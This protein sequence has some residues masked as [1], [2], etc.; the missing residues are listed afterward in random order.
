MKGKK[1]HPW[2]ETLVIAVLV[3]AAISVLLILASYISVTGEAFATL[4][5]KE[6]SLNMLNQ[7]EI[8]EGSGTVYCS[9]KC[10]QASKGCIMA[11]KDE[12]RVTCGDQIVGNYKCLCTNTENII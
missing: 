7:A 1:K 3:V 4:P 9:A 6:G 5:S 11:H 2:D 12:Q 8:I 10:A